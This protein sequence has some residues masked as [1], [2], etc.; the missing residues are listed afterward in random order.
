MLSLNLGPLS[1]FC[2]RTTKADGDEF[3][4]ASSSFDKVG[5]G[6]P[7][8]LIIVKETAVPDAFGPASK[9]ARK[10]A[11]M[12]VLDGV[13][14]QPKDDM[15][16]SP[17]KSSKFMEAGSSLLDSL[18]HA[19]EDKVPP[20][21]LLHAL[22]NPGAHATGQS[23]SGSRD[24]PWPL[25]VIQSLLSGKTIKAYRKL[26]EMKESGAPPQQF[27]LQ[28][29]VDRICRVGELF[30]QSKANQKPEGASEGRDRKRQIEFSFHIEGNT[31]RL[32]SSVVIRGY[33]TVQALASLCELDCRYTRKYQTRSSPLEPLGGEVVQR[34]DESLWR[35]VNDG[36]REDNVVEVTCVNALDE[37]EDPMLWVSSRQ[38]AFDE[39]SPK[40][41]GVG[42]AP[43]ESGYQRVAAEATQYRITQL[44]DHH[45][46]DDDQG[47]HRMTSPTTV[48]EVTGSPG[49]V[50]RLSVVR[51][52][53][54]S[55][56]ARML[57]CVMPRCFV[58]DSMR[59]DVVSFFD[60]FIANLRKR[61]PVLD[62]KISNGPRS[63]FYAQVK[64]SLMVSCAHIDPA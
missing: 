4:N 25:P 48:A 59:Q 46:S 28:A 13:V 19:V 64:R 26:L 18:V 41:N 29:D 37:E 63:N 2:L 31:V 39:D 61:G 17:T 49:R 3:I 21:G 32:E 56:G 34:A 14:P 16:G 62:E 54:P 1:C 10:P 43:P 45:D 20:I 11:A 36:G 57:Y 60:G 53:E 8:P 22:V 38:V 23:S 15:P 12:L 7:D 40:I 35:V 6:I 47:Y 58:M 30:F 55:L 9:A 44:H 51:H 42:V 52:V 27:L 33:D 50:F 5:K 24:E